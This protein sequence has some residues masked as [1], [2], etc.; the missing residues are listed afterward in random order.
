MC[1]SFLLSF[2]ITPFGCQTVI[3]SCM[4]VNAGDHLDCPPVI[5]NIRMVSFL[6]QKC[7]PL[8]RL[9]LSPHC[10]RGQ[11]AKGMV[12]IERIS[13]TLNIWQVIYHYP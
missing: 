3:L 12:I 9:I 11:Q 13:K 8:L 7:I 5:C 6:C 2:H 4:Q 1:F 10:F